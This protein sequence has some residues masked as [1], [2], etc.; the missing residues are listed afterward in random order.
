LGAMF[1]LA[2]SMQAVVGDA[3]SRM[4]TRRMRVV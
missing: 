1:T 3:Y 2:V 4:L